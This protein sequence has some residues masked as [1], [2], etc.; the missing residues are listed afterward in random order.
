MNIGF[1]RYA[2]T[3]ESSKGRT[4]PVLC[5]PSHSCILGLYNFLIFFPD[6]QLLRTW[7]GHYRILYQL[8]SE[9]QYSVLLIS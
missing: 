8:A 5:H 2:S 7:R 4:H 1:A 9:W 3:L 6:T